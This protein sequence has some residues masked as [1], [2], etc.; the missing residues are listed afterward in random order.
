M[1]SIG[2]RAALMSRM[3]ICASYRQFL[4]NHVLRSRPLFHLAPTVSRFKKYQRMIDVVTG[5]G[6]ANGKE[7]PPR[8]P[9]WKDVLQVV[10][11]KCLATLELCE[12]WKDHYK[13]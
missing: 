8:L 10:R 9:L 3:S 12:E 5:E 13:Y 7:M 11:E 6:M 2:T 1:I 4:T